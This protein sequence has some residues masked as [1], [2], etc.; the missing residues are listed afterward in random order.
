MPKKTEMDTSMDE[1]FQDIGKLAKEARNLAQKAVEQY[2]AE[3]DAIIKAQSHDS[4]RI[5]R[6]LDGM[7]DFCF[8]DSSIYSI[9][10]RTTTTI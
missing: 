9:W 6:C 8:Y 7:L 2:S 5:E 3:V 4:H 1:L 10:G